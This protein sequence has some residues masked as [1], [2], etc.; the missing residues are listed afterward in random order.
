MKTMKKIGLITL[1]LMVLVLVAAVT[2][3]FAGKRT[4]KTQTG[5]SSMVIE[6]TS[7]VHD[8]KILVKDFNCD[9]TATAD[10]STLK[11]DA[12]TFRGKSKS[13]LSD[14]STMD[15]KTHD[16]LKVEKFPEI[17]FAITKAVTLLVSN[18]TFSGII[19]GDIFLAG[20]TRTENIQF[21]G[22]MISEN[23][24]QIKGSKKLKM[25]DFGI[26]PPTAMLG[27]LKTGD[28]VTVTFNL[29]LA[30]N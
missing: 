6:G 15:K 13:I 28:A 11:I 26:D 7:S 20:K 24:M 3:G 17:K 30:V 18:N 1:P 4:F 23:K 19:T 25:T 27:A 21:T 2:V 22:K 8:W 29:V 12:I 10:Q 9:M 16:A 14:N 5:S